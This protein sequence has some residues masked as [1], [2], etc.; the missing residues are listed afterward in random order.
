MERRKNRLSTSPLVLP[1]GLGPSRLLERSV[2]TDYRACRCRKTYAYELSQLRLNL[3]GARSSRAAPGWSGPFSLQLVLLFTSFLAGSFTSE[4][5]FHT[6]FLAGLQ[7]EGVALDLLD[8]VFLL[9]LAL[10]P[11]QS[12]LEGFTLLKSYFCQTD[13]PPNPSGWTE[14]L[15]QEFDPK[16]RGSGRIFQV[17]VPIPRNTLHFETFT[18][19]LAWGGAITSSLTALGRNK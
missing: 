10:E 12:V 4:S 8:N 16:S 17:V 19:C 13:T 9:H 18:A 3:V 11:T 7:V 1:L 6:L 2:D 14:Q 15:L 5:G